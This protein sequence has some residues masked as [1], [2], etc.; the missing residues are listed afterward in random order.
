MYFCNGTK[1]VRMAAF[2]KRDICV[3]LCLHRVCAGAVGCEHTL[4]HPGFYVGGGIQSLLKQKVLLYTQSSP[5]S[6]Q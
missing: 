1:Q 3:C 6:K 5:Q 4:T 2:F